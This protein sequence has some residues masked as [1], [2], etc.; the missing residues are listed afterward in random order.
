MMHLIAPDRYWDF[1]DEIA[2]MHR[3]RL[4]VFKERLEWNVQATDDKEIDE[5]DAHRPIYLLQRDGDG[6]VRG[7][8]RM[9]PT[10]GPTML[11]EKFSHLIDDQ[12]IPELPSVWESSRFA[13]D[14][15]PNAPKGLSGI[16]KATYELFGG[17]IEFG[18]SRGLSEIVTVTDVRI[19]RILR[20]ALW[21]L[22]R[23]CEP[24]QL[25][26]TIAVV[27]YLDVSHASLER[28]RSAGGLKGPILWAPVPLTPVAA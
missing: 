12:P 27:G 7:C 24:A 18:L 8:V 15:P 22:D 25:G 19:E 21:P 28:V 1:T 6:H 4:R 20:R 26:N 23:I 14:V 10:S 11:R 17:M 5:F 13:L 9:L 16:A 2:E 3:L